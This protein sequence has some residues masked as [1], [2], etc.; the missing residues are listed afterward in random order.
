MVL[1]NISCVSGSPVEITHDLL[2]VALKLIVVVL[3]IIQVQGSSDVEL[4]ERKDLNYILLSVK[5]IDHTSGPILFRTHISG[6]GV[7]V[8]SG[9]QRVSAFIV[10][11]SSDDLIGKFPISFN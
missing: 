3:R 2:N 5:F 10:V 9:I 4:G 6:L 7:A 8:F 11:I 1:C